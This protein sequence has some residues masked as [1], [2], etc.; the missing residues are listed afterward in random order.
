[1]KIGDDKCITMTKHPVKTVFCALY[2][3]DKAISEKRLEMRKKFMLNEINKGFLK[4]VNNNFQ[5]V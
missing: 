4:A 3:N 2:W 5:H 1:M